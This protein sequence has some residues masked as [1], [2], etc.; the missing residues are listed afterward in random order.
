MTSVCRRNKYVV[1]EESDEAHCCN[2]DGNHVP[3]FLECPVR[4]KEVAVA[5][6]RAIQEVSHVEAVKLAERERGDKM[7]V[8]APQ[9]A[10]N[11]V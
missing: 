2:C 6:I 10:V 7:A 9:P 5:R 8:D 1:V 3:K 4:M 11:A